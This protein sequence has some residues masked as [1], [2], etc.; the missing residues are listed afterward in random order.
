MLDEEAF[1]AR[2]DEALSLL[3][4]DDRPFRE[5]FTRATHFV[6]DAP[7]ATLAGERPRD[8]IARAFL[9]REA[10]ARIDPLPLCDE[11]FRHGD[12]REQQAILSALPLL[13]SPERFVPLARSAS[14]SNVLPVFEALACDNPFPARHFSDEAFAQL[15]LKVLFVGLPLARVVGLR[16]RID[17]ELQ[18]MAR[19][20]ASERRAAGRA[21]PADLELIFVEGVA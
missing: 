17:G 2:A 8:A 15:V 1:R 19:D 9:L 16:D 20:Y 6:G 4:T 3:P 13:P 11:L 7:I 21:V 18:R 14:R 12:A 10:A 5:L